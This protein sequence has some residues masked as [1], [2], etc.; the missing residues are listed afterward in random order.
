MKC[1]R[2]LPSARSAQRLRRRAPAFTLLELLVVLAI[3]GILAAIGL[4]AMKGLQKS[5]V[6]ASATQQLLSDFA[7]ARQTAIRERTTVHV[8]FVPPKVDMMSYNTGDLRDSK[9][10]TNLLTH[11]FATYA[12]FAERTVGDQP[13][14]PHYRYIGPWRTLPEGV[15][16][17]PWEF[18]DWM[19]NIN[20]TPAAWDTAL[21]QDRPFKFGD[22][23]FPTANGMINRVPHLAF[24]AKGGLIVHNL[25]GA[26]VFQDEVINLARAS[27][28]V[29]RGPAGNVLEFDV[30]ESPPGNSTNNYNRVRIDGLTGRAKIERPEIQ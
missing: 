4:P 21:E 16:I 8:I 14:Q 6:M 9:T 24:D 20:G 18:D 2:Q 27:V 7:L 25:S 1:A 12:L 5:N 15:V 19:M 30:R 10:W 3:M 23:R 28:L 29:Q 13:G 17:A 11:P 26:R 22:F